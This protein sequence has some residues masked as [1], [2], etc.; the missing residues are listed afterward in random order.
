M[1]FKVTFLYEDIPAVIRAL[2]VLH[3]VELERIKADAA[4]IEKIA[5][6]KEPINNK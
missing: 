3:T 5:A 6:L 1:G 4:E 2:A